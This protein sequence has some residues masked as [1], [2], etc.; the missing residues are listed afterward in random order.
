[1]CD[2]RKPNLNLCNDFQRRKYNFEMRRDSLI[3]IF[4]RGRSGRSRIAR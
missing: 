4:R 1:M 3:R 2:F